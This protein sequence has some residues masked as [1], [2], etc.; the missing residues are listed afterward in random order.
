[1]NPLENQ[2]LNLDG[3]VVFAVENDTIRANKQLLLSKSSYF[4]EILIGSENYAEVRVLLPEWVTPLSLNLY[5][6]YLD[7]G[8]IQKTDLFNVQ[9]LLWLSDFFK[10]TK[11]QIS[12]IT[13]I[14]CPG[15][16]KETVLLFLQDAFTKI[17]TP[18]VAEH[19]KIL[20]HATLDYSAKNSSFIFSKFQSVIEKMEVP[21]VED[22]IGS[23]M[24]Q[25]LIVASSDN[26]YIIEKIKELKGASSLLDLLEK[27]E[28]KILNSDVTNR[29]LEGF[30][31][32]IMHF[33]SGNFYRESEPFEISGLSWVLCIWS[34]EHEN[35]LE[36]SLK[37]TELK[38]NKGITKDS[39][40]VISYA[41]QINDEDLSGKHPNLIP[42]LAGSNSQDIIRT[43]SPFNQQSISDLKIKI[44]AK[45]EFLYS[46]I[47]QHL[48]KNPESSLE[49][50][51]LEKFSQS[52]L[53]VILKYKYLNIK[54]EDQ[55]LHLVGK[56]CEQCP[57]EL[58]EENISPILKWLRWD[59]IT[60][61]T[62]LSSVRL[63]PILKRSKTF[64]DI[65]RHEIEVRSK[66]LRSR[67]STSEPRKSYK[68]H[69]NKEQFN[70]MKEY[71]LALSDIIFEQENNSFQKKDEQKLEEL[72]KQLMQKELEIKDLKNKLT[73]AQSHH[74]HSVSV[75]SFNIQSSPFFEDK[76]D[77]MSNE[78]SMKST[79]QPKPSIGGHD[80]SRNLSI[81]SKAAI[82]FESIIKAK[83][84]GNALSSLMT[85]LQARKGSKIANL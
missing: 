59:F 23:S 44:F 49:N 64:K 50:E 38:S 79:P 85:K 31:W 69:F 34:F 1:M 4:Q 74:S 58:C 56:W 22:L 68:A 43:I 26:S 5:I 33:E 9:K 37:H 62:L 36:V 60:L 84:S 80:R 72:N 8:K 29:Q 6:S 25:N 52:N 32:N 21:L 30:T 39:I 48:A 18:P 54:S 45:V 27:E 2:S 12:L 19:W 73:I 40:V 42:I 17:S 76:E 61:N 77:A 24:E 14:I 67:P 55:A 46:S 70:S 53:E 83:K 41:V 47:L 3:E 15:L 28:T 11:L 71:I 81:D 63:Y 78:S 7:T 57:F 35:K 10:D 66:S 16:T 51:S 65:F 13:D 82:S 75:P 20:Y